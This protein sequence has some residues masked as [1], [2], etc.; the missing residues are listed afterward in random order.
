MTSFLKTVYSQLS[1]S[2]GGKPQAI[3]GGSSPGFSSTGNPGPSELEGGGP[4]CPWDDGKPV[5][6]R[7]A[8]ESSSLDAGKPSFPSP[9]VTRD[10]GSSRGTAGLVFPWEAMGSVSSC[11]D[12]DLP[13]NG[14]PGTTEAGNNAA[15]SDTASAASSAGAPTGMPRSPAMGR[16]MRVMTAMAMIYLDGMKT[17]PI[18]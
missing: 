16:K 5:S 13:D 7:H 4:V 9:W 6:S 18:F 1:R 14:G 3:T 8:G 10:G 12:G 2:V 17:A 11:A 15:D